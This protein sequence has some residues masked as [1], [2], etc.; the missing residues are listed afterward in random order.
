LAT[1]GDFNVGVTGRGSL[2]RLIEKEREGGVSLSVLGFG[3]GNLQDSQMEALADKGNGN[4]GYIDSLAEAR[5]LLVEQAGGTLVTIAKDV[6]LQVEFNPAQVASYRLI[7]YEN[8][9]LAAQ[10]FNDDK[11]DA[12]EIG[13][14]HTVTAIYEVVPAGAAVVPNAQPKVDP[15]KYQGEREPTAAQADGELATVKLRFK[16]PTGDQSELISL[17]IADGDVELSKTS[18]DFRFSAAVAGFGM[19]LRNSKHAGKASYP[20]VR[21]LAKGAVGQDT[22][23]YR[24][25]FLQMLDRAESLADSGRAQG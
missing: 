6:K 18:D 3:T 9:M 17:P 21:E 14:G 15:L 19:L 24:K 10:D 1:D 13:A 5:K 11:K 22:R 12:G 4:Y 2:E 7:G 8:R 20:A 16:P 23:G 25:E